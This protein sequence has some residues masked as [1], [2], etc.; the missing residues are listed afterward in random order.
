VHKKEQ[1]QSL[2]LVVGLGNPGP[3][4]AGTRHNAGFWLVDKLARQQDMFFRSDIK[5]HGDT[6]RIFLDNR[7]I[8][9]LKPMTYMNNSGQAV[10]AMAR[11]YHI[12]LQE[13]LVVHDE[14]DLPAGTIRLKRTG[15]AGGHKGVCNLITQLGSKNFLRLRLGIGHPG[16]SREVLDYVLRCAPQSERMLIEHAIEDTLSVLPSII[17]G[18]LDKAIHY[19]HSTR[20]QCL[21][22]L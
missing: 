12:A 15:G 2:R 3:Q 19:L 10:V 4:Y 13:I 14:L 18:H 16:N 11:F 20:T 9:L 21:D 6:C 1:A 7:E 8:W 22:N 5:Y 17:G